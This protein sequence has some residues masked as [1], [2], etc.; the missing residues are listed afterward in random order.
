MATSEEI[1]R[2]KDINTRLI[3]LNIMLIDNVFGKDEIDRIYIN[4]CNP[5]P[6]KVIIREDL[7]IRNFCN[8]IKSF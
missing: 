1:G 7:H 2:A 3:V 8:H 4:F 5:W 6:R